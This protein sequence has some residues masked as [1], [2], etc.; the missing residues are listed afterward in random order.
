MLAN[1]LK[2][3][4]NKIIYETQ[5]A[6]IKGTQILDGILIANVV[7]DD[8]KKLNKELIMFKVDFEKAYDLVKWEYLNSVMATLDNDSC[9]FGYCICFG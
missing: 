5:S 9:Q 2:L 4:I 7:V 3:V 1:R 6:F 8:A